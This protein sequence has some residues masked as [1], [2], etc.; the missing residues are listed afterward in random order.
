MNTSGSLNAQRT[1]D[2]PDPVPRLHYLDWLRVL[3]VLGVVVFHAIHPFDIIDWQIKNPQQSMLITI[4]ILFFN[5]CGM[6]LFFLLSGAG[7][8]F[9]LKRR[10]PRRYVSERF[11]RLL[12]P[13]IFGTVVLSPIML[14]FTWQHKAIQMTA[15]EYFIFFLKD[16]VL[17]FGPDVVKI[18]FHLWFVGFLFAFSILA[19]PVFRWLNKPSISRIVKILAGFSERRGGVLLFVLP[20]VLL[21]L[22]L[23]P[24]FPVENDWA[25]FIVYFSYFLI[26]YTIYMD[27]RFQEAIRRD[28]PIALAGGMV[29]F[30]LLLLILA[31][32]DPF[33]WAVTPSLPQ[34][35]LLWT[36]IT[37]DG[38][39]WVLFL[40]SL[41][42]RKLNFSNATLDYSKQAILPVFILH[43]PVI[44]VIAFYVVQMQ[45]GILVKLPIVVLG[46]LAI[47]LA[48][49]EYVIRY[50][51][52]FRLLFGMKIEPKRR[53]GTNI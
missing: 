52:V 39:C 19:L 43:Q 24:F 4:I 17:H 12:L 44:I 42:M 7:S 32:G 49:Y 47:S 29:S 46:S 36:L 11:R 51:G 53:I 18:G 35:Y 2:Q 16:E 14:Y 21:R 3:A 26:G 22:V 41:G 5:F 15:L 34:F 31:T 48:L 13:F 10:T 40:L 33:A 6:H 1:A 23:Q 8:Y 37:I 28:W 38:W 27:D 9:S 45:I 50:L 20:L 25:D 30:L